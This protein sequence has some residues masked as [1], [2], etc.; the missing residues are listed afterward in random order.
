MYVCMYVTVQVGDL[1]LILMKVEYNSVCVKRSQSCCTM[2][3]RRSHSLQTPLN[4]NRIKNMWWPESVIKPKIVELA[5]YSPPI[6]KVL[7]ILRCY[8]LNPRSVH[9]VIIWLCD[10][11]EPNRKHFLDPSLTSALVYSF[12]ATRRDKFPPCTTDQKLKYHGSRVIWILVSLVSLIMDVLALLLFDISRA[13]SQKP[14][15]TARERI[16]ICS[17]PCCPLA[18]HQN[19]HQQQRWREKRQPPPDQRQQQIEQTATSPT[20]HR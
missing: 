5:V 6:E 13:K 16:S 3:D 19:N 17:E 12:W 9:C 15:H 14:V 4:R 18:N 1:V 10:L 8:Y 20:M 7:F 2:R 11:W